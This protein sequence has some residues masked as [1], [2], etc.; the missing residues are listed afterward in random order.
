MKTTAILAETGRLVDVGNDDDW[1]VMTNPPAGKRPVLLCPDSGNGGC[2]NRLVARYRAHS[3]GDI[4]RYLAFYGGLAKCAHA[5]VDDGIRKS[6]GETQEH[7]WLKGRVQ[8]IATAAGYGVAELEF[9]LVGG[10]VIA[11]VYVSSVERQRVEVQ[12]VPTD[13]PKRNE[14][15]SNTVWLL[16]QSCSE[17]VAMTRALFNEPCVKILITAFDPNT[18]KLV[19]GSP[20]AQTSDTIHFR[21]QAA[22]TVLKKKVAP[23]K[24]GDFFEPTKLDLSVF[25]RQVWSGDRR[26]YPR[27]QAHRFAGWAL[28]SDMKDKRSWEQE[29]VGSRTEWVSAREKI[30]TQHVGATTPFSPSSTPSKPSRGPKPVAASSRVPTSLDSRANSHPQSASVRE[31]PRSTHLQS[32]EVSKPE[33]RPSNAPLPRRSRSQRIWHR[34]MKFWTDG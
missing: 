5:E 8:D 17:S 4:T 19:P 3:N 28:E 30:G 6:A 25:L 7:E 12:R 10:R 33:L 13:I 14:A 32:L 26:W 22:A 16:R 34:F 18:G 15:Y 21:V 11:D 23:S 27:G 2:S 24:N 29:R 1:S 9:P 31:S 20:W